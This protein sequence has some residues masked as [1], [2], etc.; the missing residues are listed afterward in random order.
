MLLL[1]I[2]GP[3]SVTAWSIHGWLG[4]RPMA[5]DDLPL[6][7]SFEPIDFSAI[8]FPERFT[9]VG[10]QIEGQDRHAIGLLDLGI[11]HL[12]SIHLDLA[13]HAFI[14][15]LDLIPTIE[16]PFMGRIEIGE[17]LRI[18]VEIGRGIAMVPGLESR[19]FQSDN[20]FC[21]I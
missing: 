21:D 2:D 14:Q 16:P 15:L 20:Y 18:K 12:E 19:C 11:D 8:F 6:V 10:V 13:P 9:R 3:Q 17:V 4:Q 1:S 7:M 5:V